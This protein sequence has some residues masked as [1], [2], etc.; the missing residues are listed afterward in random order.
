MAKRPRL[1]GTVQAAGKRNP[2]LT[3]RS[4]PPPS[5]PREDRAPPR[6]GLADRREIGE[7][8]FAR[9]S[10]PGFTLDVQWPASAGLGVSAVTLAA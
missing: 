5:P 8:G 2:G 3:G 1:P 4:K 7:T 10:F 9:S 6:W